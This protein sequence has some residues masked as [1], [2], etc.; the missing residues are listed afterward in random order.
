[1][2]VI[3]KVQGLSQKQ[4]LEDYL[5][6]NVP[7]IVQNIEFDKRKWSPIYWKAAMGKRPVQ[8]YDTL[9]DLQGVS[10][11][12]DYLRDHFGKTGPVS[13]NV[14][15]I[16]WYSQLK[17]MDYIWSDE[18]FDKIK[19]FWKVP[20]LLPDS[21]Y[22]VPLV[23][24]GKKIDPRVDLFPYRGILLAARGARTRVHRDPFCSDAVVCQYY[25]TKEVSLYGPDRTEELTVRPDA[26]NSYS[27]FV[28]VRESDAN[29]LSH[30]PD[31]HG[32]L[33][34]GEMI[35][36]PHGWLHD[37]LVTS[38]SF[39]IT[40]NFIHKKGATEFLNYLDGEPE[41]DSEYEVLNFFNGLL[42][43]EIHA[44]KDLLNYYRS[45]Q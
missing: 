4:F 11:L 12:S 19:G 32:F 10:S 2:K 1:V 42:T 13:D 27:G 31:F 18:V 22:L 40:W 25:G 33:E 28:D 35:Y 43:D 6:K 5:T 36:I 44:P 20:S 41:K 7:V 14:P 24:E 34:P 15:Y 16:R 39:S 9:F 37:V 21:D 38:D 26:D 23:P 30:E 45:M 17:N 29:V 3:E 8:V